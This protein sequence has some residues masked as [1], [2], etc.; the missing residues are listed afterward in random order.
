M[1]GQSLS[2]SEGRGTTQ[3]LERF[4]IEDIEAMNGWEAGE[5][6]FVLMGSYGGFHKWGYPGIPKWIKMDDNQG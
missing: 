1:K 6:W 5:L 3:G 2:T 4:W